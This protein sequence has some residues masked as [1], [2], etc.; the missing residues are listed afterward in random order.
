MKI[1]SITQLDLKGTYSYADYVTWR[2]D[3]MVELIKGKI[4]IMTPARASWH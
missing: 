4:F 2:F 1:T 3:Q